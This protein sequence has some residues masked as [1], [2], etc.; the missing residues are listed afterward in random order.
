MPVSVT[1]STSLRIAGPTRL[2]MA[3][4]ATARGPMADRRIAAVVP[5]G[6]A[7]MVTVL[8]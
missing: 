8:D 6:A 5:Q 3:A 4:D 7:S 1:E 2:C